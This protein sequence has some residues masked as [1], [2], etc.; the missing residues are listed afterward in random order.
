MT[1]IRLD[2]GAVVRSSSTVPRSRAESANEK[3]TAV[4]WME[5]PLLM[6]EGRDGCNSA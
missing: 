6:R 2:A 5:R 3:I 1:E 4:N